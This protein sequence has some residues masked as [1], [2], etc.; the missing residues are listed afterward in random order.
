ML[1]LGLVLAASVLAGAGATGRGTPSADLGRPSLRVVQ[2]N[3]CNSGIARCYTGRSV[4]AAA[5]V[6]RAERPDVVT[7]NEICRGDLSALEPAIAVRGSVV[8]SAFEAAVDRRTAG[9]YR[10]RNGQ[11]F[12]VGVLAR[13]RPAQQH[14]T[15]AAVYPVQDVHDPEQRVWLCLHA[16]RAFYACTTHLASTS[17]AI[18]LAQCRHL[19]RIAIPAVRRQ[20]G[21]EPVVV[22]ADLNLSAGGSPDARSC[23]TPGYRR[24]DDGGR[25]H[26]VAIAEL[27]VTFSA[28]ISLHGSTDHPALL[29]DLTAAPTRRR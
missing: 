11:P 3:L 16:V 7:L 23:L 15:Y 6:I 14:R 4:R 17:A 20:G 10:C 9:A 27:T 19:L 2:L 12:G 24:V 28:S 25:Q 5:Q 22:G 13:L 21:P 29:A 26:I 1:A 18:A 8:V